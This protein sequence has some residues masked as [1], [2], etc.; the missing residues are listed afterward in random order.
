M[1]GWDVQLHF[2]G[3]MV[4]ASCQSFT[5]GPD[6]TSM[7]KTRTPPSTPLP[8]RLWLP[9]CHSAASGW[10]CL[11]SPQPERKGE[12][13][14]RATLREV[15]KALKFLKAQR[16]SK[17]LWRCQKLQAGVWNPTGTLAAP[18]SASGEGAEHDLRDRFCACRLPGLRV[19]L[20]SPG[21]V[22]GALLADLTPGPRR[23]F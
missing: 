21:S 13:G 5:C 1:Q 9:F 20:L 12:S 11:G 17:A 16:I 3:F 22:P 10:L 18:P 4:L 6:C 14:G 19:Q 23:R 15:A 2:M 8:P 7:Q